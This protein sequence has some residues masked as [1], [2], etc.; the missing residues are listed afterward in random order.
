MPT[1]P[2]GRCTK[3][4]C[5]AKA[6]DKGRCAD[7]QPKPWARASAHTQAIDRAQWAKA[8]RLTLARDHGRCVRCGGK[9]TEVDHI[10]EVAD[11][12]SLYDTGN[13]QSLCHTCHHAKTLDSRR[14]RTH[15][16]QGPGLAARLFEQIEQSNP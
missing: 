8:R 4:G 7:H 3:P 15:R 12:G 6:V 13:L 11:G 16:D 9:A 10:W 14:R 1:R 5:M 2:H